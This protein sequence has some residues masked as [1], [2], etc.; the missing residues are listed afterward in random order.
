VTKSEFIE[1]T[2]G[3]PDD[4]DLAFQLISED[5]GVPDQVLDIT[6]VSWEDGDDAILL[7][8]LEDE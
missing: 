2:K 8:S 4:A 7:S 6:D 5:D 3:F 1:L